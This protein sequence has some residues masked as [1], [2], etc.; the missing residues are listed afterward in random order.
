MS[1][2]LDVFDDAQLLDRDTRLFLIEALENAEAADWR[3]ILEPFVSPP[4][5]A[6]D[7]LQKTPGVLQRS[8]KALAQ[9]EAR[10]GRQDEVDPIS[11]AFVTAL[12]GGIL[13][14]SGLHTVARIG[15][16]C[17]LA[18]VAACE[19]ELWRERARRAAASFAMEAALGEDSPS[20]GAA[21][22]QNASSAWRERFLSL[23]RPRSDGVYVGEC[24]FRRWLRLGHHMDLRKNAEQLSY[25]GSRGGGGEWVHYRRYVRFLPPGEDGSQWALVLQDSAPREAA[26]RALIAGVDVLAHENPAKSEGPLP[27]TTPLHPSDLGRLRRRI[28]VGRYTYSPE[29]GRIMMRY[30]AADGEYRLTFSLSHGPNSRC[31]DILTWDHYEMAADGGVGEVINFSLGRLPDWKGGGLEDENKDHF[32]QMTFRPKIALEHNT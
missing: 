7:V 1:E 14:A 31:S 19:G 16:A 24:K 10:Q 17:R 22:R 25:K 8:R 32:P 28:C 21:T 30:V 6:L 13:A 26:E 20:A 12:P 3:D 5:L 9:E 15:Q 2:L 4:E 11:A 18:R 23:L 27:E 29:Q